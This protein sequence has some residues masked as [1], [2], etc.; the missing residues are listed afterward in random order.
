MISMIYAQ[1]NG[2]VIAANGV[3][4]WHVPEDLRYF[5]DKTRGKT[6]LMGRTTWEALEPEFR[7]LPG[8][9]NIVL[10]RDPDFH[11]EDAEVVRTLAEG[12]ASD[13]EVWV[14][15]GGEIYRQA[16]PFADQVLITQIDTDAPG[17]V[18]AP[19]IPDD[20]VEWEPWQLSRSGLRY[21]F[22]IHRPKRA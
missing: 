14:I 11:P 15:G 12:L 19:E 22:G 10:S 5:R 3:M 6:L 8:R 2:R 13:D 7:P 20:A 4:P 21:R 9:R 18:H 17:D 16:L 1:A